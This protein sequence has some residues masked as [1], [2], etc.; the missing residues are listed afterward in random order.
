MENPAYSQRK[1]ENISKIVVSK[2]MERLFIRRA[3]RRLDNEYIEG[4]WGVIHSGTA[5][6]H[7][8]VPFK[9]KALPRKIL[10]DEIEFEDQEDAAIDNNLMF[11]GSIHTHPNLSHTLFSQ[12]DLDSVQDNN[13]IIMGIMSV[14]KVK[15]RRKVKIDYWLAVRPL[16][17]DY[18]S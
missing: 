3:V 7:A 16:E 8:F 6:I 18:R 11:L 10:Y 5:Y 13:E 9:H 17:K 4:L 14:E 12:G 1:M 15:N 2:K